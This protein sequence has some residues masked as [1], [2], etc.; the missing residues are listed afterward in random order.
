MS[1]DRFSVLVPMAHNMNPH[2]RIEYFED[3][4][5]SG[6]L[7]DLLLGPTSSRFFYSPPFLLVNP[8]TISAA[9]SAFPYERLPN[10]L[11]DIFGILLFWY[12]LY[13]LLNAASLNHIT[14]K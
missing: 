8:I 4:R 5:T 6:L 12:R 3:L 1:P 11:I 10:A 13:L 7:N 9:T 14:N 2:N